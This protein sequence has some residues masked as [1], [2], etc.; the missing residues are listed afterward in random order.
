MAA[1]RTPSKTRHVDVL[2]PSAAPPR[3]IKALSPLRTSSTT[4]LLSP[5]A[6]KPVNIFAPVSK[7]PA[8][9]VG[10]ATDDWRLENGRIVL[11]NAPSHLRMLAPCSWLHQYEH[12]RYLHAGLSQSAVQWPCYPY[13]IVDGVERNHLDEM[14]SY[15]AAALLPRRIK[16]YDRGLLVEVPQ[17]ESK[18]ELEAAFKRGTILFSGNLSIARD[19]KARPERLS[20]RLAPPSAGMGSA[21]YRRF[22][23][24]RFFRLVLEDDLYRPFCWKDG[25]AVY[26]AESGEGLETISLVDFAQR[27]LDVK[28]NGS[29]SVAK[30]A[31]R[32]ELGLTTTTPTVIFRRDQVFRTPDIN[33]DTLKLSFSAMTAI[34]DEFRSKMPLD[35]QRLL[36]APYIPSCIR[37]SVKPYAGA[38]SVEMVWQLDYS[39]IDPPSSN[40]FIQLRP[41]EQGRT[42]PILKFQLVDK[43]GSFYSCIGPRSLKPVWVE[44]PPVKKEEVVMTDGCSLISMGA[45]RVVAKKLAASGREAKVSAAAMPTVAQGRTGPGKGVWTLAPRTPWNRWT[46]QSDH[47]IWIEVRDS[48]WKFKDRRTESFTFELHSLPSGKTGSKLGKRMFEVF[49]HCGVPTTVFREMLKKQIDE[50][51]RVLWDYPDLPTLLYHVQR[52]CNILEDRT[53]KARIASNPG[54]LK[55][56]NSNGPGGFDED[57]D[58]V[59]EQQEQDVTSFVQDARLD[60]TSGAPN[61]VAEVV[62]EML[63]SGFDPRQN[64]HLAD[65]LKRVEE[66]LIRKQISFRIADDYSYTAF[67]VADH[68][69]I[70]EEGQFFFQ[71]SERPLDANGLQIGAVLGPALLTRSPA[72]QPCDIQKAATGVLCEAYAAYCDVIVV[73]TKGER[74]LCSILSGGD[75]DGDK[76]VVMTNPEL[77][78]AFDSSKADPSFAD[79]PF[80]DSDW[81]EVDRRR[82]VDHVKPMIDLHNDAALAGVFMEGLHAGT[83]YGVLSVYHTTLAY[84]LGLDHP[85]T[86]EAGHLF[87]KALDGRK[88]GFSFSPEKWKELK[89]KFFEPYKDKPRWTLCEDGKTAPNNVKYAKRPA[90]QGK[91]VMDELIREGE[92]AVDAAKMSWSNRFD[93]LVYTVEGD[94]ADPWTT[95]WESALNA[96]HASPALFDDL[97]VILEHVKSIYAQYRQLF[98][99]WRRDRELRDRTECAAGAP[100]SP[101]KS[102]SKSKEWSGSSRNQKEA[103]LQLSKRFWSLV[104]D[105]AFESAHLQ[106][107]AGAANVRVLMASCAYIEPLVP[108]FVPQAN[109]VTLLRRLQDASPARPPAIAVTEALAVSTS[110]SEVT[111]LH[112]KE[113]TFSKAAASDD[114]EMED[115]Y[116]DDGLAWSQIPDDLTQVAVTSLGST[117]SS[118]TATVV[119]SSSHPSNTTP[120]APP[121]PAAAPRSPAKA[122]PAYS[123]YRARPFR[124]VAG[125]SEIRFCYDMAHRDV[126]A[127]RADSLTR[128]LHGDNPGATGIQAPKIAPHIL[129]VL[130]VAK[131]CATL[132]QARTKVR[133]RTLLEAKEWPPVS[134]GS[135][136]KKARRN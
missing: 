7:G 128:A 117:S 133:P 94:L 40:A 48:Q 27:Y 30:Y 49:A 12:A 57:L 92:K 81:F 131:R 107:P 24:D 2:A 46:A 34:C 54:S 68:L 44:G 125:R 113:V 121:S 65:K 41:F 101:I 132:A 64:P 106:G 74:L 88:Q 82:V 55:R 33:S 134:L 36:P 135:P 96:R 93:D 61:T 5:Q 118:Q 86:S 127:L 111:V 1:P 38:P 123:S 76:L 98:S 47:D 116:G 19:G 66:S 104:V 4:S 124:E 15:L 126:L 51:R 70:L 91:H 97:C 78:A 20:V 14:S 59:E 39:T 136:A 83:Q 112:A 71:L 72:I 122:P 11:V 102:P 53:S 45:M 115:S 129:D 103:L 80:A 89:T 32:F 85:L 37:G 42:R 18:K 99:E 26:W 110:S 77:V 108:T 87:C 29:M 95:A 130:Q 105:N 79:P 56:T 13:K 100:G 21:L 23:S 22:G 84:T 109:G 62:V 67:V 75:Y 52:Q 63:Q 114:V 43:D 25:T 50:I 17:C 31:A 90:E 119:V 9:G 73:S 6:A 69:G 28:L 10:G 60:P 8:T 58:Q 35:A 120:T 16:P 3:P